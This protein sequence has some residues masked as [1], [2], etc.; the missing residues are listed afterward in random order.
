MKK[1][2]KIFW[3]CIVGLLF[4][5]VFGGV[6]HFFYEWSGKNAIVGFFFP[7]NESVWEHLKLALVPT[8]IY[9]GIGTIFMRDIDIKN[10]IVS[11][12]VVLIIPMILI[13]IIFYSYTFFVSHSLLWVDILTYAISVI[14]A[15]IFGGVVMSAKRISTILFVISIIGTVCIILCYMTLTYFAPHCFLFLDPITNGYGI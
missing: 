15:V 6:S 11:L 12:F 4:I 14:V 5:L 7:A 1:N 10:Y 8:L 2:T 13:P 9:F 3:F